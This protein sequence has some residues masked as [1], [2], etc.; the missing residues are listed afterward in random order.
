MSTGIAK[1]SFTD[2]YKRLS[3]KN[4]VNFWMTTSVLVLMVVVVGYHVFSGSGEPESDDVGPGSARVSAP[5]AAEARGEGDR[6]PGYEQYRQEAD[7]R[8]REEARSEGSSFMP[9][10][11]L[12][13]GRERPPEPESPEPD[14]QPETPPQQREQVPEGRVAMY[15]SAMQRIA[16]RETSRGDG[17]QLLSDP[18]E[19][20]EDEIHTVSHAEAQ[21][22]GALGGDRASD[23]VERPDRRAV[24]PGDM[25]VGYLDTG[26]NSKTP[27]PIRV[28]VTDGPLRGARLVGDFDVRGE[29]VVAQMNQITFEDWTA[30]IDAVLVDA[31]L[32]VTSLQTDINRHLMYRYG[33]LFLA[34]FARGAR[35][36]LEHDGTESF[37]SDGV[38]VQGRADRT[39]KGY[40]LGG[41]G[42]IA[43]VM[44]D[45]LANN[46]DTPP[47]ITVPEGELVGIMFA[48][49][50]EAEWLPDM[51]DQPE[52]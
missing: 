6:P 52:Y 18:W 32:K 5:V 19:Q 2:R 27:S 8:R 43:D 45:N 4:R 39:T 3:K 51:R 17:V 33:S 9:P 29:R 22:T 44:I 48:S 30:P 1:S 36:V 28:Y 11:R 12:E 23:A 46:F 49:E 15:A 42:G 13:Y 20:Q 25:L 14:A 41:L 7:E 24:L 26:I 35:D 34:G 47:T 50:F 37:V 16:E 31:D 40:V 38:V 21:G 10:Q